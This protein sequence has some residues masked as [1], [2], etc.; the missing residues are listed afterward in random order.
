MNKPGA[1]QPDQNS[2]I[3]LIHPRYLVPVRPSGVVFDAWSVAITDDLI[4]RLMPRDEAEQAYPEAEVIELPEHVLLPGLIN[5]HTHSPMNL[6]RGYA[7]DMDLHV[8]LRQHIWPAEQEFVGPAFVADGTRLAIAEMLRAG[9]TCF[10]DMY[11]FPDAIARACQDAGIRASIGVPLIEDQSV[12]TTDIDGYFEQGLELHRKWQAEPLLSFT[13]SPHAP[14]TVT[15]E[16]LQRVAAYSEELNIP[17]HMHLLETEWDI[18][19][20]LQHHDLHPLRRLKELNLLNSR[21]QAVHMTQLS[22]EDISTLAEAGV[23]V[24][25]C[26]QSNLKLAS[27]ICPLASLMEAGINVSLGTDGAASNNDLDLLAEAQTAA[28]LAKGI[29]G[30][31]ESVNAFQALEMMTING[32]MALGME[33]RIGSIEPGKAADFCAMDLSCPETQP[34]HHVVSQVIYA[35]SRRQVSDVWVAGRR[36]LDSGQLTSID[37]EETTSK[38]RQWAAR[39]RVFDAVNRERNG[40]E[41]GKNQR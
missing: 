22:M 12:S 14:Y 4:V 2:R 15:D 5:M 28:L 11:F 18:K 33:K 30:N 13:L 10:N 3:T 29:S 34:L 31:A 6:L 35:A 16:T 9:T 38:A 41:T 37:L 19:H 40:K 25:H 17:V 27:G 20:S 8:W 36:V 24:V 26:P 23:H 21:L 1:A 7:D 39:L 32:A